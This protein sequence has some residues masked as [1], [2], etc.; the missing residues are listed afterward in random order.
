ML[1]A[2]VLPAGPVEEWADENLTDVVKLYVELH[3]SPELSF[4]EEQ[5]AARLADEWRSLGFEVTTGIGGHG[6]VALMKNGSGPTVMLRCDMDALPVTERTGLPYASE[7][8]LSPADE[9]RM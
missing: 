6:V 1:Y 4:H 9:R 8:T 2:T 7:R 5:T 3:K